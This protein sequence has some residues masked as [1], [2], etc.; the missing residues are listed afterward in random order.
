MEIE[1]AQREF[2][3]RYY[4]W[5]LHEMEREI[6]DGYPLVACVSC[7]ATAR[8]FEILEDL[9]G[10]EKAILPIALVKRAHPIG[11][12]LTGDQLSKAEEK[13]IEKYHDR[14]RRISNLENL[15]WSARISG[16]K[17]NVDRRKFTS[18]SKKRLESIFGKPYIFFSTNSFMY[19]NRIGPWYLCSTVGVGT[20]PHYFHRIE[21]VRHVYLWEYGINVLGWLGIPGDH[22]WNLI[23]DEEDAEKAAESLPFL[24]TYFKEAVVSLLE[25]LDHNVPEPEPVVEKPQLVR[26]VKKKH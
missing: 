6:S 2:A 23:F 10:E 3:V 11:V 18:K 9:T 16:E 22:T 25:G 24:C 13:I 14:L 7:G 17:K 1:E 19:R 4:R 21:A 12:R 20:P 5:A 26:L 8:F 15:Y